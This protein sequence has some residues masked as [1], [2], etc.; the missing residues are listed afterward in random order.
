L[1]NA[2][3]AHGLFGKP[4]V[5]LDT[6]LQWIAAWLLESGNTFNKPTGFERRDGKF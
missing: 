3:K 6:L 5:E 1:S 4:L 2:S